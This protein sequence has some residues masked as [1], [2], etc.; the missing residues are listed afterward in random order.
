MAARRLQPKFHQCPNFWSVPS[1]EGEWNLADER[2]PPGD[3]VQDCTKPRFRETEGTQALSNSAHLMEGGGERRERGA[4]C[5]LFL[6]SAE[7]LVQ[8]VSTGN[9][10]TQTS[11][12][13]SD[14]MTRQAFL[15]TD[16]TWQL[17][18]PFWLQRTDKELC[19]SLLFVWF[20][21][22]FLYC[23]PSLILTDNSNCVFMKNQFYCSLWIN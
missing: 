6:T 1:P 20:W 22:R 3:A 7:L 19:F 14:K 12:K 17:S 21:E 8:R 5:R 4:S 23:W 18:I 2:G 10:K 16:L 11:N 9:I 13:S 15:I